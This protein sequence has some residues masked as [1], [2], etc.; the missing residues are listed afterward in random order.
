MR[1]SGLAILFGCAVVLCLADSS[2]SWDH[3]IATTTNL[4]DAADSDAAAWP[5]SAFGSVD[6]IL[7]KAEADAAHASQAL[8]LASLSVFPEA[9]GIHRLAA[10]RWIRLLAPRKLLAREPQQLPQLNCLRKMTLSGS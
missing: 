8:L 9:R 6:E 10:I 4:K 3:D 7:A 2:P 1:T 5:G